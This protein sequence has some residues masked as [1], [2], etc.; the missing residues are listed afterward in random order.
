MTGSPSMHGIGKA[1]LGQVSRVPIVVLPHSR[2]Q[3]VQLFTTLS[4]C[5]HLAKLVHRL[6]SSLVERLFPNHSLT[7]PYADLREFPKAFASNS[8]FTLDTVL[9][10]LHNCTDLQACTWTRDGSLT[11]GILRALQNSSGSLQELEINGRSDA[12]YDPRVLRGF[13]SLTRISLIMPSAAVVQQLEGWMEVTGRTLRSLTIVCKVCLA[14]LVALQRL[15]A[16]L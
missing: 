1:K 10:G 11:S 4:K 3:V 14:L 15:S 2:P 12:S 5:S 7:F 6:G 9:A 13:A 16:Q 8:E